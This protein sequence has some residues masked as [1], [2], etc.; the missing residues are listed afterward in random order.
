MYLYFRHTHYVP[1]ECTLQVTKVRP[2]IQHSGDWK[3]KLHIL[4]WHLF[5]ILSRG[6][7][8]RY[9]LR[10][11]NRMVSCAEVCTPNP[12]LPFIGR[13]RERERERENRR[14]YHIGPCM[15][16]PEA[17]GNGYYPMLLNEIMKDLG[18]DKSYYMIVHSDNYASLR[19]IAKVGFTLIGKGK[20]NA[21]GQYIITNE[22]I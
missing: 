1:T 2:T 11:D 13:E 8:W 17:R 6:E 7:Y 10:K 16:I 22:I 20:K 5:A 14:A 9:E 21:L 15:T 12:Q 18:T 3:G 19:G 4:L